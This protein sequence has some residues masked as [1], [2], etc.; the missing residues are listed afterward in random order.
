[1]LDRLEDQMQEATSIH[2]SP[3]PRPPSQTSSQRLEVSLSPQ[4]SDD[5]GW[6]YEGLGGID[7]EAVMGEGD[8]A[9]GINEGAS[10]KTENDQS[11]VGNYSVPSSVQSSPD[12]SRSSNVQEKESQEVISLSGDSAAPDIASPPA[13]LLQQTRRIALDNR[14]PR[15]SSI[16][17]KLEGPLQKL[18]DLSS[19]KYVVIKGGEVSATNLAFATDLYSVADS[20]VKD[21]KA[22]RD[23]A[24]SM[25]KD[26]EV[27]ERK[28]NE[29]SASAAPAQQPQD[30]GIPVT[31]PLPQHKQQGVWICPVCKVGHN[32]K[33]T[34][35]SCYRIHAQERL[36]CSICDKTFK[37]ERS[38][39]VHLEAHADGPFTCPQCERIFLTKPSFDAHERSHTLPD[40]KKEYPC[41]TC[42]KV[43]TTKG[44]L[45]SHLNWHKPPEEAQVFICDYCDKALNTWASL[46]Q[47]K[48]R[49]N[50]YV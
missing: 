18:K 38:M 34:M 23:C 20:L 11:V 42:G 49:F 29:A 28:S 10:Q 40:G 22:L 32:S 31:F 43:Y 47:H 1:M 16:W 8:S 27:E 14:S 15:L 37:N 19:E 33:T 35:Q 46:R 45:K 13:E 17:G 9:D 6:E 26:I 2:S 30:Q 36:K 44:G 5:E 12:K 48:S 24:L 4:F 50:H 41:M 25:M 39:R 7:L 21:G 3:P